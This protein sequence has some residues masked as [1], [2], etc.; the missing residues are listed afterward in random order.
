[1]PIV[2]EQSFRKWSGITTPDNM[3]LQIIIDIVKVNFVAWGTITLTQSGLIYMADVATAVGT[4]ALVL[5]S[6]VY[7]SVKL[8]QLLIEMKWSTEDRYKEDS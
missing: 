8:V 1:M 6:V 5:I 3:Q 7:T 4:A 2:T